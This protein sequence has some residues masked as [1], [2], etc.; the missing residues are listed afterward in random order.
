MP[1]EKNGW[2]LLFHDAF[3][4]QLTA[5]ARAAEKAQKKG[6]AAAEKSQSVKLLS[7]LSD[8]IFRI[9]PEDPAHPKFEQ[10][11]TLSP[12]HRGWRRAKFFQ[13]YRLFFR[14][15]TTSRIV[16]FAW[17]YD[18]TSLRSKG[19]RRDPYAIFERMLDRGDPPDRWESRLALARDLPDE[20]PILPVD[21]GDR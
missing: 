1:I 13:R 10:G 5:L 2:T 7:A 4:A 18:A 6:P 3:I 8:H 12:R 21:P 17:V 11:N 20:P 9:V 15:H 16:V 19:G 14:F